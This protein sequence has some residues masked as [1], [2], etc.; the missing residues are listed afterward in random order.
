MPRGRRR[1]AEEGA[2]ERTRRSKKYVAVLFGQNNVLEAIAR[3]FRG[4][5]MRFSTP[6]DDSCELE[7]SLFD[8]CA[9]PEQVFR[10]AN[11][12]IEGMRPVLGIYASLYPEVEVKNVLV[13]DES[14]KLLRRRI[15]WSISVSVHSAVGLKELAGE[16]GQESLGSR[17]LRHSKD[18]TSLAEALRL[19]GATPM[20]WSIVY[21]VIEFLGGVGEIAK[22]GFASKKQATRARQTANHYRHLGSRKPTPLPANPPTLGEATQFAAGLLKQWIATRLPQANAGG[23]SQ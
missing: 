4:A 13:Y 18:D 1:R 11:L 8:A 17:I 12:L 5:T 19:I 9:D 14:G 23:V 16:Q 2:D 6:K 15:R 7:S 21:D 22:A 3:S 10:V 20:T